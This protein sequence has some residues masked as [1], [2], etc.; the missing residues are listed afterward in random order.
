MPELILRR[1]PDEFAILRLGP[2]DDIPGWALSSP[3]TF[4]SL[5][6]TGKELS[7]IVPAAVVP[8]GIEAVGGWHCLGIDDRFDPDSIGI[9]DSVVAPLSA[10]GQSVFVVATFDTDYFLVR[11]V[12]AATAALEAAGHCVLSAWAEGSAES[13]GD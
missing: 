3:T 12:A 9:A 7:L 5:T 8:A 13:P 6:R 10:A 11:D 4:T 1:L 2:A